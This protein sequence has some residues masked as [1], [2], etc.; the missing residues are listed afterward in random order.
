M[1]SIQRKNAIPLSEALTACLRQIRLASRL[2]E[3]LIFEAWDKASGAS[4][5]TARRYY[6]KGVLYI[7]LN[8]SA[9]RAHLGMQKDALLERVN[10]LLRGEELFDAGD[11]GDGFVKELRLK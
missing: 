11:D 5:F 10:E 6:S 2:N 3:Q 9:A 8:S 1:N 4:A 7:T